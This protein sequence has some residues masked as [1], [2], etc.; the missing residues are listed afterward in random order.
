M[1]LC[2]ACEV[3]PG[4]VIDEDIDETAGVESSDAFKE[5]QRVWLG[6]RSSGEKTNV[7][8][9]IPRKKAFAILVAVSHMAEL[10]MGGD[11][12]SKFLPLP[13]VHP[14]K[15]AS[16][17]V[18]LDQGSDGMS[19]YNY[20]ASKLCINISLFCDPSHQ[21][22]RDV[23]G[24]WTSCHWQ[25]WVRLMIV[26]FNL[27][28]GPFNAKARL[29]ELRALQSSFKSFLEADDQPLLQSY[30]Q[31]LLRECELQHLCGTQGAAEALRECLLEKCATVTAGTKVAMCR[32]GNVIDAMEAFKSNWF[33]MLLML[34]H[35]SSHTG[36][37]NARKVRDAMAK[38]SAGA[39]AANSEKQ[40][41][42]STTKEQ[43]NLRQVFNNNIAVSVSLL[44]DSHGHQRC[45]VLAC[46]CAPSRHWYGSQSTCLR[47][48]DAAQKWL[49]RQLKGGL[50]AP[51]KDTMAL[52]RSASALSSCGIG[53]VTS[54]L[55]SS[56]GQL[57]T[58]TENIYA[59]AF[60]TFMLELVSHRVRRQ[61]WMSHSTLM[62]MGKIVSGGDAARSGIQHLREMLEAKNTALGKG[63]WWR[64]MAERSFLQRTES[65]QLFGMIEASGHEPTP[66]LQ[67]F[68]S[69]RFKTLMQS[70][71]VEDCFQKSRAVEKK[72]GNG[73]VAD[74]RLYHTLCQ[75]EVLSEVHNLERPP[76]HEHVLPQ[77]ES[78]LIADSVFHPNIQKAS[79]DLK[80]IT[81]KKLSW[82]S[83]GPE[84]FNKIYVE[85]ALMVMAAKKN[86]WAQ[87][88]TTACLS[89]LLRCKNFLF[90]PVDKDKWRFSLGDVAGLAVL[91]WP[92]VK[93]T[94]DGGLEVYTP[95]TGGDAQLLLQC[96]YSPEKWHAMQFTWK[97]PRYLSA[98]HPS[99]KKFADVTNS[100]VVALPC[101][102]PK[103][104]WEAAAA[105]C[106]HDLDL[107]VLRN[108][109][110]ILGVSGLS[111][112]S[113]LH[114]VLLALLR[115]IFEDK[116]DDDEFLA[117]ILAKRLV[118]QDQYDDML[119]LDGLEDVVHTGDHEDL[120]K[121]RA[122]YKRIRNKEAD[123]AREYAQHKTSVGKAAKRSKRA[124]FPESITKES[125]CT[126]APPQWKV[127][128]D[129]KNGRW[130]LFG[131]GRSVSRSFELYGYHNACKEALAAAWRFHLLK[132]GL[133][134][135]HCP[136]ANLFGEEKLEGEKASKAS[137]SK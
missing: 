55:Q 125:A 59:E 26:P 89:Q 5:M 96:L 48:V 133:P 123:Y 118:V 40:E 86:C 34:L 90:K 2:I 36:H 37:V 81:A 75:D 57:D 110:S 29:E 126:Y 79:S 4:L 103:P 21:W 136:H 25:K 102:D 112:S 7:K 45:Q 64:E 52:C 70:K 131:E 120:E 107:S 20:M 128:C 67:N 105:A 22:Q 135:S 130:Q 77:G 12:I 47:D 87:M 63:A 33:F 53:V 76:A 16:L 104:L 56:D 82:W 31:E 15:W 72:S 132:K 46:L 99:K 38:A 69:E 13:P 106:F 3:L 137:S 101:S 95:D 91:S 124:A 32:F 121:D 93:H 49:I 43:V 108:F 62:D 85:K 50:L 10:V 41:G 30:E 97:G 111:S 19:A 61:M 17:S 27:L 28:H 98:R 88:A 18:A 54:P 24:A 6:S 80:G 1:C 92:A 94:T 42:R 39:K 119:E 58:E 78:G 116:A 65:I 117:E 11:V 74:Y 84:N 134:I 44:G 127:Y 71:V 115:H 129:D 109:A 68:V 100:Q 66:E 83:P 8:A 114:T 51:L 122:Q 23:I 113:S 14:R 73:M 9:D 60:G 35:M